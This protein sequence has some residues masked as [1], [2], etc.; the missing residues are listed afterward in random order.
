MEV[1]MAGFR[2]LVALTALVGLPDLAAA[3][4]AR[5]G[6][7]S[8]FPTVTTVSVSSQTAS[9]SA[10]WIEGHVT[11]DH[12]LPI[13]GAAVTAQGRDLLLA[14]TDG[15]GHFAFRSVP[16]GTY[17]VRVQ[18]R[19][20]VA[21]KREFLQ[22]IP[23]RGTR[24]LVR[25]QRLSAAAEAPR[26]IAAGPSLSS[27]MGGQFTTSSVSMSP[28]AA[29]MTALAASPLSEA[30]AAA[31]AARAAGNRGTS[32]RSNPLGDASG[33]AQAAPTSA[34]QPTTASQAEVEQ[35]PIEGKDDD[36]DHS[37]T[38]W[39]LR[40]LKR[41]VLRDT[42]SRFVDDVDEI[43][44]LW[45]EHK[46]FNLQE[47][48]TDFAQATASLL[49]GTAL[50]GRVQLLTASSFDK[51]FE[52]LSSSEM[53]SGI[54]YF[55]LGAPVSTR[56]AWSVEGAVTQGDVSSWFVAGNYATI[57]ADSHGVDVTS[58][59]TRQRYHGANPAV[60]AAFREDNSR[61]AGGV[62]IY[63][64]W[65]LTSRVLLTYGGRYDHYDYLDNPGL[66]SPS[67][68][69][70]LSPADRT[71]VRVS[72]AQSMRAPGAEEFVPEP[73]GT[74]TIPPQ[75]TFSPLDT[76]AQLAR[77]R[78]RDMGIGLEREFASFLFGARY[79]RQAVDDQLVTVFGRRSEDGTPRVDLGHYGVARGGS[80]TADG[81]GFSIAR[82][83]GSHLRGSLEY[84]TASAQWL[85]HGEMV[86]LLAWAPSAVRPSAERVNDFT[87]RVES[88]FRPTATRI[89][90]AYKLNTAYTRADTERGDPGAALRFDVQVHQ[91]LPF[92]SFTR[93]Q[94]EFLV[95]VRN[96]FH[97]S[98]DPSASVYDEL[99]VVRPPKRV[100]GGVTVQF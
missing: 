93:A 84:R 100:V 9:L 57:L 89:I 83:V 63:D 64:R 1:R 33:T 42:N 29:V 19:G 95:A 38:A 97:D 72:V 45:P 21:S 8:V 46:R 4:T 12:S 26:V 30:A 77:E 47:W 31:A 7:E 75:R 55:S 27:L 58:S 41:S 66:F 13:E 87:A 16:A 90:A 39:R 14:E 81:W 96:L 86:T 6:Q 51:P 43:A 35:T 18:G 28:G 2:R 52:A 60:L 24:H 56:T 37:A 17:L 40:H 10:G 20:F 88:E 3:Q 69:L 73:V 34:G 91:G 74:L 11:D 79:F 15:T 54:A 68:T 23:A 59:Y 70:A 53:P 98:M 85:N 50:S 25:L 32:G 44:E 65:T 76:S 22:V 5:V 99:L 49:S 78:T 48:T 94:W 36:H 67:V 61:N 62:Q 82:P 92:M 80:F 71:W